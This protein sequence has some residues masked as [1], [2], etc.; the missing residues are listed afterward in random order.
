MAKFINGKK[1]KMKSKV[2]KNEKISNETKKW[3]IVLKSMLEEIYR[4]DVYINRLKNKLDNS[5][6]QEDVDYINL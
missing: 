2:R 6:K 4:N 1:K 3:L 5:N